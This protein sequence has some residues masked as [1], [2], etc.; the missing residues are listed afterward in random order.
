MAPMTAE[1]KLLKN[2]INSVSDLRMNR[3]V[4]GQLAVAQDPITRRLIFDLCCGYIEMY[5]INR[6]FGNFEAVEAPVMPLVHKM[7]NLIKEH[8]TSD[9]GW[10]SHETY[11]VSIDTASPNW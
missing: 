9:N 10:D 11:P 4:F 6:D 1:A 5:A 2:V 8:S 7:R 3:H